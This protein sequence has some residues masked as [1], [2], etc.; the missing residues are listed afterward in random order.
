MNFIF[1][2]LYQKFRILSR[3]PRALFGFIILV[4]YVLMASVGPYLVTLDMTIEYEKRYQ[5]PSRSNLLGTDYA[6]RDIFA[7][8]VHGST[9]VMLI[10]FSTAFFAT[11]AAISIGIF[12]GLKGGWADKLIMQTI[13]IFLTLPQFPIMAIFA[14]LFQIRNA[15]TFGF[16]LAFFCWAGLARAIRMQVL[17]LKKKEFIEVCKVMN[18]PTSYIIFKELLPNMVPFISINFINI[19]RGAIIAGV[20]I[21]LLGLVPLSVTN[22]GMMLNIAARQSG[23]LYVPAALPY[24][25]SPIFFI[26]FFQFA[27]INFSYGVEEIFDPRLR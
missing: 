23:A 13:D 21:M 10:A 2:G 4:G 7:Q 25:L 11:L 20:G 17:T 8:I 16:L 22:W 24:L 18:M 14:G 12:A 1:S 15:F 9:D 26:V 3:N 27:L 19:A 5:A 6:G